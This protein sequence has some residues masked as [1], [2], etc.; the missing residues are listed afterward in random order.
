V[1]QWINAFGDPRDPNVDVIDWIE[2][3]PFNETRNY[4]QRVV[5]NLQVY[6]ALFGDTDLKIE[7]DLRGKGSNAK[8]VS[9]AKPTGPVQPSV[10][11][12]IYGVRPTTTVASAAKPTTPARPTIN[13]VPMM[14]DAEL[15]ANIAA[16]DAKVAKVA[17][18][19][20]EDLPERDN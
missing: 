8:I 19:L 1:T 14:S 2:R 7:A 15:A 18:R 16:A 10:I 11:G 12:V 9:I 13:G 20:G 4:V 17:Y 5:E 6:R 3:I